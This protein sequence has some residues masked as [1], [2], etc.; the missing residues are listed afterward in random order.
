M[1]HIES[2]H[3]EKNLERKMISQDCLSKY[4]TSF[5]RGLRE[6]LV[7]A[8]LA[9][10]PG[11][12]CAEHTPTLQKHSTGAG[13]PPRT[14]EVQNS[15]DLNTF[16]SVHT[17]VMKGRSREEMSDQDVLMRK[18]SCSPPKPFDGGAKRLG[19]T[20][21]GPY[22]HEKQMP[23]WLRKLLEIGTKSIRSRGVT[24]G[25][26]I[27]G[28][29][30]ARNEASGIIP[31]LVRL[32]KEDRSVRRAF[33]CSAKVLQVS[34]IPN[35]GGFCGYRNIQMQI[36]Y[37][38]ECRYPGYEQFPETLPTILQLQDMIEN[39]WDQGFNSVGRIE[40]GGIRGTRKYIGTPESVLGIIVDVT[41]IG[42]RCEA[43]SI[44]A[45][46]NMR[47]HDVLFKCIADYFGRV[48][49]LGSDDKVFQ[50]DLPPVYLQHQ[51][52]SMTV[53]GFEIRIDGAANL[54]VFDPMFKPPS[55]LKRLEEHPAKPIDPTRI[56]KV[57]RR[58]ATYFQKY[59]NFEIL[60]F[61]PLGNFAGA[62]MRTSPNV[63]ITGTPGV[64][65]TVHCEQLAQDTGLRH[66]SINQVAKDHGCFESYDQDLETW[67]VD[68][69]KLLDAI[70]DEMAQGGLL[71]DWHACD[72][73]PK[74]WIDLVV[75]LRCASTSVLY[76]RLM[77][78]GYK[79]AKLQ[80]NLDAE[81]FGVLLEEARE[82]F[83]EEVVVELN[84]E[85]DDDVENNCARIST[86]IDC[87]KTNQPNI[88]E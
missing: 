85:Q 58:D 44:Q 23:S 41:L 10:H 43:G 68:E 53:I 57:Y 36:S 66:L 60:R 7:D 88:T 6:L 22:A 83:D 69:D 19:R 11:L 63:I 50:T 32:C 62:K 9:A 4:C 49:S 67:V 13:K 61:R 56:L 42:I 79:Q 34:K 75:V 87:W 28:H 76:D 74:S 3:P 81:I 12:H 45:V 27:Q 65:K 5:S 70:E 40:T 33:L 18:N 21:L 55:A 30:K 71:V 26:T 24:S 77:S 8:E 51:G 20:E 16:Q 35:E 39:A 73:F 86:W 1:D 31:T 14:Q 84:S 46:R 47:A 25:G 80:E 17:S 48:C 29:R 2:C 64:G 15:D 82:A 59:K 78:R 37:I 54:L 52:H 38:R 72:L